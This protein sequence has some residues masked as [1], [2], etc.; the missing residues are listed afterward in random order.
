M[1][2]LIQ[3]VSGA[4]V[5]VEGRTISEIGR[6]ILLFLGIAADDSEEDLQYIA[7]KTVHLRI[8]SDDAGNLNRSLIDT[9]GEILIVSQFT[10]L[11][12]TRKGRRPSFTDAAQPVM[13]ETLYRRMIEELSNSCNKPVKE[14]RFGALMQISLINDGP[15]TIIIDSKNRK[16]SA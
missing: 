1:I 2:A 9:E 6:G 7:Q 8:F 11:A 16:R 3:R 4:Q 5:R 13:A 12:D 15:V 10:L 14:G